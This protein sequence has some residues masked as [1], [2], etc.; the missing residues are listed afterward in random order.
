MASV[1]DAPLAGQEGPEGQE[2]LSAA[3]DA[4]ESGETT[5]Q[6]GGRRWWH[7]PRF[8]RR[9]AF[10]II[11]VLVF[12]YF[13]LPELTLARRSVHALST[14]NPFLLTIAFALEVASLFA[15]AKLTVVVLPPGSLSLSSYQSPSVANF[16]RLREKHEAGEGPERCTLTRARAD[17]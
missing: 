12:E 3:S 15:Y 2:G 1:G 13:V 16:A 11:L 7:V 17:K 5:P 10:G 6:R 9:G 14:V 4:E 8:L